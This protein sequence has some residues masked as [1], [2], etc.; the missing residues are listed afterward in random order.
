MAGA[1][2]FSGGKD[3]VALLH[4]LKDKRK[5]LTVYFGNTGAVYP[6]VV[7]FVRDRCDR[8]GYRLVEVGPPLEMT[9]F[10]AMR[11]LPS[12]IVPVEASAEMQPY[13]AKKRSVL[14]QSPL[15]CC[16]AMVWTPLHQAM[17]RDGIT[18]IYR[19]SKKCDG[20]VGVADGHV[21]DQG[22]V[23]RSPLWDW[24]D[25]AVF[26]YL[27]AQ[28]EVL[29]EHYA[30][31]NASFDCMTCTGFLNHPGAAERL[32]WTKSHYPDAW[33]RIASRLA[34]VRDIVRAEGALIDEA[35]NLADRS[36]NG[37]DS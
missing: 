33:P 15:S 31:V 37:W 16:A 2:Q 24:D 3:S 17:L 25:T 35:M 22:I 19:G 9:A 30:E 32:R 5:E 21:D 29:P 27:K 34:L 20:H 7:R 10:H 23:Y 28:D 4:L 1:I 12:D 6:H 13:L 11:G 18:E 14:L 26:A 36:V 8:L